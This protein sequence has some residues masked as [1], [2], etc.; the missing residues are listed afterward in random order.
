MPGTKYTTQEQIDKMRSEL[1]KEEE[2][3]KLFDVIS[4]RSSNFETRYKQKSRFKR[5]LK[6]S[7]T[8]TFS[9]V[10]IFLSTILISILVT[11]SKGETPNL[12][13]IQLYV[14]ESGSMEPTLKVGSIIIS[15]KVEDEGNLSVGTIVTF[16]TVQGATV[17][18][19][20]I[21]VIY[22]EENDVSYIT[23]GDNPRNSPDMELLT[24]DRVV[25]I[26]IAKIPLT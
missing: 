20:I 9:I 15:K 7:G 10:V 22:G 2:K 11:K 16:K 23:K 18:H 19:R 25:A 24:P 8:I 1:K 3:L 5:V 21:E 4:K 6:L 14:V 13:G 17:T 26:F 12:F